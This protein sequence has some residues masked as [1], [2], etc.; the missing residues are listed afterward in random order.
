MSHLPASSIPQRRLALLLLLGTLLGMV[1]VRTLADEDPRMRAVVSIF[2]PQRSTMGDPI[3]SIAAA[4]RI[5]S[6]GPVYLPVRR[7]G[8]SFIYPPLAA[9]PYLPFARL[10]AGAALASLAL[11]NRLVWGAIV[12][13]A[14]VIARPRGAPAI[15]AVFTACLLWHPLSRAVEL[16]QAALPVTLLI[17]CALLAV[18]RRRPVLAGLFYAAAAAVKPPLALALPLLVWHLP[19]LAASAAFT[20]F[21]LFLCSL[22]YAG[23][24]AHR[25]YLTQVLPAL[26]PGYAFFANASWNG[27]L[28]RYFFPELIP[29]FTLA[30]G[31]PAVRAGTLL[32]GAFTIAF[33][34]YRIRRI[35]RHEAHPPAV[36]LLAWLAATLASPLSWE[37]HYAPA[38]LGL[39]LLWREHCDN[40]L[41]SLSLLVFGV[42]AVFIGTYLEV[43][44]SPVC[45]AQ[46]TAS[47][48]FVGGWLLALAWLSRLEA[49]PHPVAGPTGTAGGDSCLNGK[50]QG[51]AFR[52]GRPDPPSR[53]P[54]DPQTSPPQVPRG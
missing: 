39:L 6:G 36:F 15:V 16:N 33:F 18:M 42:S 13:I 10:D 34:G 5:A 3:P 40:P 7:S 31:N 48:V 29:A 1:Q 22:A 54:G 2:V 45:M 41:P 46:L 52:H 21:L 14:F 24:E 17:G 27:I 35:A 26:A 43:P 20:G 12:A 53:Q 38:L 4:A 32:L 44:A 28:N 9:L 47:S 19:A 50:E 49:T 11:V 51:T 23:W 25:E 37:H 30:P 8:A